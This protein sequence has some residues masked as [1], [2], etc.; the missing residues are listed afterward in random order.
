[1]FE[2]TEHERKDN[3]GQYFIT[4]VS[5]LAIDATY[6]QEKTKTGESYKYENFFQAIPK[7]VPFRPLRVTPTP[8]VYGLQPALVV[9]KAGEEIW[10]DKYGRVKVQFFWDRIGKKN[11]NS[12]CWVRVSQI[13]AGKNWGW[14]TIPRM[15]QEVLVDFL[16]GDPDQPI[17]VGRVYNADQ[18]TPYTLPANQ[19]QSGIKSRSSKQGGTEDFNEIRFE[20][21]KG[22]EMVTVHAQKDMETTVENDDTQTIQR[23]R[24]IKVD[25]THTETIKG[26]TTIEITEGNLSTTLKKGNE[27]RTLDMGNQD[28]T[29]KMG[30]QTT[31]LNMGNQTTTI[32]LGKSEHTAMQSIELKV[33]ASSIK[34]DQMGVTIKGMMIKIEGTLMTEIKGSVMVKIQ[35]RLR[36][37][38]L[39]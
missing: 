38:Q 34:V 5:H 2:L 19:T 11:E 26:N 39:I 29:L 3:N 18:T 10:T 30:N 33:G 4:Q 7:K 21:K 12:S 1:M 15:G 23:N 35:G 36:A 13:W 20:D 9:G 37:D 32:S 25:G 22:S 8:K 31:K 6:R 14:V 16:E 28:I 24:T 17:I 27:T